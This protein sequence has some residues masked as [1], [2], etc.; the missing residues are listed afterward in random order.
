MPILILAEHKYGIITET[1]KAFNKYMMCGFINSFRP[2]TVLGTMTW[3]QI[4][5]EYY[6]K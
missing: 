4:R 2:G 1:L 5:L 6:G 3:P